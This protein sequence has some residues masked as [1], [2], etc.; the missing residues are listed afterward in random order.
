MTKKIFIKIFQLLPFI[1]LAAAI[2][3][4]VQVI[5]AVKND[6]SPTIFGY[7]IF[8]VVSPSMEDTIMTG[9]LIFV[10]TKST[11]YQLNDIISFREPGDETIIITHRIIEINTIDGNTTYT[12]RG[13]NNYESL[14]FETNFSGDY[15]IGKYVSKSTLF[16]DVYQFLF[17]G[18]TNLIYA[19]V[20]S[21]FVILGIMEVT[22]IIKE[23]ALDKKR[24]LLEEK[25]KMI[26]EELAKLKSESK[27]SNEDK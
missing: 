20:V 14:A 5:I 19:G 4:I 11:D 3:L 16:G 7:A 17:R 18:G 15:I 21:L 10:N 26:Q 25:E 12:T 13:D 9:D 23:V 1:I 24:K 6:R 2:A 22:N 8:L 27:Q